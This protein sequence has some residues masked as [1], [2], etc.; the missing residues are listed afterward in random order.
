MI[1]ATTVSQR[2]AGLHS[3]RRL[4]VS[5]SSMTLSN[6]LSMLSTLVSSATKRSLSVVST[7]GTSQS[8]RGLVLTPTMPSTFSPFASGTS[9]RR[10]CFRQN[11]PHRF[12]GPYRRGCAEVYQPLLNHSHAVTPS[13]RPSCFLLLVSSRRTGVNSF[14]YLHKQARHVLASTEYPSPSSPCRT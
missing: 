8:Q 3:S 6:F 11:A 12:C 4:R 13:C 10:I 7:S 9:H 14:S 2:L 5:W 1:T